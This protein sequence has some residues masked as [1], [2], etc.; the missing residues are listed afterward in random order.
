MFLHF[1][2]N[3]VFFIHII[4]MIAVCGHAYRGKY[5]VLLFH[6]TQSSGHITAESS[7]QTQ[8]GLWQLIIISSLQVI[9]KYK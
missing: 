6:L 3:D 4:R 9:I 1:F 8:G 7:S 2:G 5:G